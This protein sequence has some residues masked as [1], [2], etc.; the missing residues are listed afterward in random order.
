MPDWTKPMSQTFEYYTVDPGTWKDDKLLDIVTTSAIEYSNDADTLGSASFNVT[1]PIGEFYVRTYLVT[2]QNG[3][4]E[5]RPLGTHLVQTPSTAFDGRVK[6]VSMDAYTPLLE[7]K[8]N[9]PPLGYT[10]LKN[11]KVIDN[12]YRL[13]RENMRAPVVGTTNSEVLYSDFV[14]NANDTW[15]SFIKD[16]VSYAKYNLGLDEMGRVLFLPVQ[17]TASL[18]PVGDFNDDNSSILYPDIQIDRDLYNVPNVV[19]VVYSQNNK[20]YYAEVVNDD[21]NSPTSTVNRGRNIVHR[22]TD[23]DFSG[24]PSEKQIKEY[25]TSLLRSLSSVEYSVT[26]SHGYCPVRVGDCVRLN[27]ARAG[28]L[29]VKARITK[30]KIECKPGC[31][32]TETAV[33]TEKLWG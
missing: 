3:V 17:D 23:P 20:N 29:D 28:I 26:Y 15:L 1:E 25:A 4:T 21:P 30:Q 19:Q 33:F 32:V 11:E 2:N 5:R 8:E 9:P 22:V 24:E 18:Q 12:A 16:L 6:K 10:I 27:Y 14:A 7:L 13:L 31:K